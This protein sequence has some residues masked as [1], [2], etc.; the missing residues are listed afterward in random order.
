MRA[1]AAL[2]MSSLLAMGSAGCAGFTYADKQCPTC[3]I[4]EAGKP[5]PREPSPRSRT[6]YVLVPGLLGFGWE[7]DKPVARLR[8]ERDSDF[9]VFWWT[10]F[11]SLQ[12]AGREMHDVY[13]R[14][15]ALGGVERL[16]V[17]GHSVGGMVVVEGLQELVIPPGK[18][19]EIATI[20]TPF[21]GM[22][23]A[24]NADR[25][26]RTTPLFLAVPSYFDTYPTPPPGVT[27]HAY[28]TQYP[29]DPVMRPT[30]GHHPADPASDPIGTV[31][32][33]VDPKADH[34]EI[35]DFVVGDVLRRR[36]D[37]RPRTSE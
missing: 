27:I 5:L 30:M 11:V 35:V 19:I 8:R 21:A 28:V 22:G 9:L 7:W 14:L 17:F 34:N 25:N 24:P 4:V 15:L 23:L 33:A 32:I 1:R 26:P 3:T 10:P 12:R 31:R 29:A 13:Q 36:R 16:V 6:L 37:V 18:R 2:V 20:G